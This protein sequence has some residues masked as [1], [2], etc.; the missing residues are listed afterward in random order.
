[1]TRNKQDIETD[2][3]NVLEQYVAPSVAQPGG[4]VSFHS[5]SEDGTVLLE[6]SGA[7]SGCAGSTMTLKMG[8]ENLLKSMVPEVLVV[9]GFDDPNS[10]VDPFYGAGFFDQWDVMD[11][12]EE[13]VDES[14]SK[15]V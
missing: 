15:Q 12:E 5:F 3:K 8:V 11:N 9:E 14:N 7:C 10:T 6:M 1:M 4:V 2:I 13:V